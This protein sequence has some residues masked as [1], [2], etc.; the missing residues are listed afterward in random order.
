MCQNQL[1]GIFEL[2]GGGVSREVALPYRGLRY[3]FKQTIA[4]TVSLPGKT[5]YDETKTQT[6]PLVKMKTAI[7]TWKGREI[8]FQVR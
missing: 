2:G 4:F 5:K 3:Y 6:H 7:Q 8:I 1:R